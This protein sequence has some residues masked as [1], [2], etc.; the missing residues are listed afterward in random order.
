M[1]RKIYILTF[2]IFWSGI[3]D[4]VGISMFAP[5]ISTI[6]ENLSSNK[7]TVA[8][9]QF[10]NFL[11]L[12]L[13][14]FN[15]SFFISLVFMLKSILVFITRKYI[16]DLIEDIK[17]D[18]RANSIHNILSTDNF[19]TTYKSGYLTNILTSEVEKVAATVKGFA[20]MMTTFCWSLIFCSSFISSTFGNYNCF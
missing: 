7:I 12:K 9:S 16:Y 4:I 2:I 15:I 6:T 5:L 20:N 19:F 8:T 1:G 11:G 17:A 3:I 14:L 13:N 18:L 10:F